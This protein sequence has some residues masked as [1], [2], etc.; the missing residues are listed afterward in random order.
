VDSDQFH[1]LKTAGTTG[2]IFYTR[3]LPD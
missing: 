1:Y 3:V 2:A